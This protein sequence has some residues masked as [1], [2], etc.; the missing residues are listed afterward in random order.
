MISFTLI[1]KVSILF[2]AKRADNLT[3]LIKIIILTS[4]EQNAKT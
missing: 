1:Y 3:D 4:K 2:K